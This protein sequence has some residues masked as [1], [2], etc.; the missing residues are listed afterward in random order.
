MY[1]KLYRIIDRWLFKRGI[2]LLG[3]Q[4]LPEVSLGDDIRIGS[5]V[6]TVVVKNRIFLVLA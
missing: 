3:K 2:I 4:P 5:Q 1:Q 6:R